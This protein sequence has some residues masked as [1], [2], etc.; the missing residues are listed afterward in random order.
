MQ[1][2]NPRKSFRWSRI[3][4][5]TKI[6]VVSLVCGALAL[7]LFLLTLE[8]YSARK[9]AKTLDQL[10]SL[11]IGDSIERV[12]EIQGCNTA[13]NNAKYDCAITAGAFRFRSL[14][15][16][17]WALPD[18]WAYDTYASLARIGLRFWR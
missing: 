10:E 18:D 17:V 11:R 15:S 5:A 14:W 6:A 3:L 1:E 9:A 8:Y 7:Y 12:E 4:K 2:M 13:G 16:T